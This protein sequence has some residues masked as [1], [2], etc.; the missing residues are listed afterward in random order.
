MLNSSEKVKAREPLSPEETAHLSDQIGGL[1]RSGLPLGPGLIALSEE[2]PRGAL[3]SSLRELADAL[4][5]GVSLD[6]AIEQQ[7]E[8]VPAHF[9]GLVLGALR[10]GQLGE[11]LG[12]FSGYLSIGTELKRKL[13]LSLAY[14]IMSIVVA[15][16]LFVF[17]H[18]FVVAMFE[19]IFLDFGIPLPGITLSML[20]VS[21]V[22]RGGW[23]AL[24]I[25]G[26]AILALWLILRLVLPAAQRGGVATGIPIIG[27]V[28]KYISWAEFCHLLAL[29]LESRLTMP[30]AVRLAGEGVQNSD[31]AR[32]SVAMAA[33]VEQGTPLAQALRHRREFP[34]GLSRLL[35]WATDNNAVAEI[36]HV[37]GEMF[38]ARARA[39]ATF[40]GTVM[41]VLSVVIVLWGVFAVIGGLMVPLV[42]LISRLSG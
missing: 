36:L 23:P 27:R 34:P 21:R 2:L 39:Q 16:A 41:T 9:R 31:M 40:A 38:E 20:L 3:R 15:I 42:H 1:A 14:P 10:S 5:Q 37:A 11:V 13:W 29:L 25:I 12:R 24:A 32:A 22:L 18:V 30:E 19:R 17:V 8:R 33:D 28:W 6:V 35:R 7:E 4:N 26:G